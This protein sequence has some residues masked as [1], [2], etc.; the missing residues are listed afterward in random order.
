MAKHIIAE[1]VENLSKIGN[2][3]L[4]MIAMMYPVPLTMKDRDLTLTKGEIMIIGLTSNDH[5]D[6]AVV[7]LSYT[8][9]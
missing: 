3:E 4:A 6:E 1:Y 2:W 5:V 7:F 9:I 8:T